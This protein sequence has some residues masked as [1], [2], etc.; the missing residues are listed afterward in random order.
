MDK[1]TSM[2]GVYFGTATIFGLLGWFLLGRLNAQWANWVF[3]GLGALFFFFLG[4]LLPS[5]NTR[6]F[7]RVNLIG[8][9]ITVLFIVGFG[10]KLFLDVG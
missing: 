5:P 9:G 1:I 2:A 3:F 10:A 6:W 8:Y 4:D 7:A